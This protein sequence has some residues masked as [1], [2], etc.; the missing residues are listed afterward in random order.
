MLD[1]PLL[2]AKNQETGREWRRYLAPPPNI[3]QVL[4]HLL[5]SKTNR[6]TLQYLHQRQQHRIFRIAAINDDFN[7]LLKVLEFRH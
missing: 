1:Y 7:G 3:L 6:I 4:E 5:N 2:E